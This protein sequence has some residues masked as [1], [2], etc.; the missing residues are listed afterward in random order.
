MFT[1]EILKFF[2]IIICTLFYTFNSSAEEP[3]SM[4]LEQSYALA[5][6]KSEAL[7]RQTQG[8][9]AAEARYQ[10]TISTIYPQIKTSVSQNLRN[11]SSSNNSFIGNDVGGNNLNS[12]SSHS[13][14][15]GFNLHQPLFTGFRERYVSE[16]NKLEI[17]ALEQEQSRNRELLYQDVASIFYQILY[18]E[19]DLKILQKTEKVLLE[20]QKELRQFIELGKSR[21]SEIQAAEAALADL[22]TTKAQVE[23]LLGA[24]KEM[25]A[26]LTTR[27]ASALKLQ[28]ID[29][30][31]AIRPL[32]ELLADS[33][34]RGD[35]KALA[36]RAEGTDKEVIA[37]E[38]ER[39]PVVY[40]EGNY[41]P[42]VDP[43]VERDWDMQVKLDLPIFDGGGIAARIEQAKAKQS[44]S[45]LSA[46]EIERIA[47]REVRIAY[48]NVLTSE[49]EVKKL[50]ILLNTT[51]KNYQVQHQDYAL[52][53]V[54]NLEVLDAIGNVQNAERRL[55]D[56]KTNLQINKIK[57]EVAAGALP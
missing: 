25:L 2:L 33:K 31:L 5:L 50:Q 49:E 11:S 28:A 16:A 9:R 40:F 35:I 18:Y 6:A 41:Y 29:Y 7:E 19:E 36:L 15:T 51:Q 43:D 34:K 24:S 39:W 27:D 3:E 54:T 44:A 20:R 52:G 8:I 57:L 47:E 23:G 4:T 55:L 42:Y 17:H 1:K 12:R 38:R 53:V 56:A 13:F 37:S 45:I 32:E 21:S 46:K 30:A 48:N 14:N 22:S 26:F 10:E